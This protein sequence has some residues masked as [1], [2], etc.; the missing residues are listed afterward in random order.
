MSVD[1]IYH[2]GS[3]VSD[4][5][6]FDQPLPYSGPS[7]DPRPAPVQDEGEPF[8][9]LFMSVGG[10]PVLVKD[11]QVHVTYNEEIFWG[12]GVGRDNRDPRTAAGVTSDGKAILLVA[13]G[14]Y[15]AS[16]GLSLPELAEVM[17]DLGS[18]EAINLDGGGSS[19]MTVGTDL[20]NR[21]TGG[22]FQRPVATFLAVM[23]ADSIPVQEES[24]V[25]VIIDTGDESASATGG[26]FE[27]ANQ[28]FYGDTPSLIVAGGDGSETVTF[29]PDL[30]RDGEYELSAWWVASFNRSPNAAFVIEHADGRDTVRVDQSTNTSRWNSLGTFTF[31]GTSDDQVIVSNTGSS[32]DT[33]VVADAIRFQS[34]D[35]MVT[36]IRVNPEA[37]EGVILHPAYPNPFNPQTQLS[38]SLTRPADISLNIYDMSGRRVST[39]T[40]G[41][42]SSGQHEV[43]WNANGIA[44]GVYMIKLTGYTAAGTIQDT[45]KLT[46]IK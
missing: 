2:F 13:D 41:R 29:N 23:P 33:F 24:D 8:A 14:R 3:T 36:S 44:S 39:L 5:Y 7:D 22:T 19:Q 37:P 34:W 28:G 20:V 25:E 12:S 35:D 18:V 26:W 40:E 9:D 1:W 17:I 46:L 32:S 4:I 31:S 45:R 42:F 30:P 15:T 6:R 16:Q 10:G 38:F 11:G 27:S 21:P 43:T